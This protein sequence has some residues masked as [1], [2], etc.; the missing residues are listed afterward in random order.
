MAHFFKD[1]FG[2]SAI[3][4]KFSLAVEAK[5]LHHGYIF[6]GQKGV[7]KEA[8]AIELMKIRN[9]ES[10]VGGYCGKC[11][12]CRDF[13]ALSSEDLLY[14]QPAVKESENSADMP[15][16]IGHE[17]AKK[18]TKKGYYKLNYPTSGN[19]S[20]DQIKEIREFARFASLRKS[21]KFVIIYPADGMN[22]EAQNALLKVLEEPPANFHFFLITEHRNQL[23]PTILSRC[24]TVEFPDLRA[25]DLTSYLK[26]EYPVLPAN[27][28]IAISN[29]NGSIDNLQK[30]ISAD[31]ARLLEIEQKLYTIFNKTTPPDTIKQLDELLSLTGN[32]EITPAQ[33][34]ESVS[35]RIIKEI[36]QSNSPQ[37]LNCVKRLTTYFSSALYMLE[38]NINQRLLFVNIYITYREE[39]RKWKITI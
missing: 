27:A 30:L 22:K 2:Q 33:V 18:G 10:S 32:G 37:A 15:D 9:C 11:K 4:E 3:C 8:V 34:L 38:R 19:I 1:I 39:L 21:A 17:L 16:Y 36:H 28:E 6:S 29:A 5:K 31:G 20:I 26:K 7:G 24:Q 35:R 12:A 23:L 14:I 25:V 13:S